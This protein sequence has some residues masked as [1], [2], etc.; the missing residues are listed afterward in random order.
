[1][2]LLQIAVDVSDQIKVETIPQTVVGNNDPDARLILRLANK[3]G[4]A[5][6]KKGT[7]QAIRDERTFSS[8]A[9]E[10]Q[11][12]ALPDDFDHIVDETFWNRSQRK[13][14]SGPV[15]GVEWQATKAVNRDQQMLIFAY[16]GDSILVYP[17]LGDG[18]DMAFEYI[19]ENWCRSEGGT[20]QPRF[21]A[22]TDVPRIDQE[23]LT[24]GI[25][26]DYYLAEGLPQAA[27]AQEDF[28]DR[29]NTVSRNEG[30]SVPIMAAGDIFGTSR[31]TTGEP[32]AADG[33][34]GWYS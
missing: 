4:T 34:L 27:A 16:R 30:D 15:T 9:G 29:W 22:D 1:M 14:L 6:M 11:T 24:L 21:L 31:H 19:S 2:T 3:I 18:D 13:L 20:P 32:V 10:E 5:L 28:M 26:F 12:G 23:L 7:F 33:R 17:A 25:I 8:I